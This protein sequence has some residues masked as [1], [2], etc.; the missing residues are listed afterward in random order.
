M[1]EADRS[2]ATPVGARLALIALGAA[3]AAWLLWVSSTVHLQRACVLLDTPY[4]PLC[5][6]KLPEPN[7]PQ[8]LRARITAN[9]GDSQAWIELTS[10]ERGVHEQALLR[11]TF[12]LAPSDP[13]VLMWR[14]GDALGRNELATA[15]RLLIDLIEYRGSGGA[16]EALARIVASGQGTALLRPYVPSASRWLP[17]V[18]ASMSTLKLPVAAALPLVS[19]AGVKGTVSKQTVQSYTRDLKSSGQ[20]ADAFGLWV[21]QQRRPTG[22]LHNGKFDEPFEPDGFNWEVTPVPPSRA[23][24]VINQRGSGSRGGVLEIQFTG[25]PFP[26]PLVKQDVFA[27]PGSY[28][29]RGQ[30]QTSRLRTEQGL[31]WVVKCSNGTAA[32]PVAGKTG[33]L[34][35]TSGTW[36]PFQ[37]TFVIAPDCGPLVS[38]QLETLAAFEAAAGLNGR[39]AFDALELVPHRL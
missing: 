35:D 39:A 4:L 9:P 18:L 13:N 34:T 21:A 31:A 33:G 27:G 38:L 5:P 32:N 29:V 22:L 37:F 14:A 15:T 7:R 26:L 20:W 17:Q 24:A 28:L 10:L 2:H 6:A 3:I 30:Y 12:A 1:S 19:E 23:G 36:Q 25:R 16:A 8:S 11:A